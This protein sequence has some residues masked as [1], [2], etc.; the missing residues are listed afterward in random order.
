M[1][2]FCKPCNKQIEKRVK[3]HILE[4]AFL[5]GG[6]R[7]D[8]D[9]RLPKNEALLRDEIL[10]MSEESIR[11]SM[12]P[13]S[14][15]ENETL[16]L[17][18]KAVKTQVKDISGKQ[19]RQASQDG[20]TFTMS[21]DA[22]AMDQNTKFGKTVIGASVLASA[23]AFVPVIGPWIAAAIVAAPF[24]AKGAKVGV[25]IVQQA[26][27]ETRLLLRGAME[28][29]LASFGM[30]RATA[31]RHAVPLS[32]LIAEKEVTLGIGRGIGAKKTLKAAAL[33]YRNAGE[34]EKTQ[35]REIYKKASN[36][37]TDFGIGL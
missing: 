33:A 36:K 29:A 5:V 8:K 12:R 6:L 2:V 35:L 4:A 16:N 34:G 37:E 20:F 13:M 17:Y 21:K 32:N 3:E 30:R 15:A 9:W 10:A 11:K 1:S 19:L 7:T 24:V 14:K 27:S 25:K 26:T 18:L 31:T 22:Y 23:L 28:S